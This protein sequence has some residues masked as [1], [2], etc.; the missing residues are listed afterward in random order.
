[1]FSNF[2]DN[3]QFLH[4]AINDKF[5]KYFFNCDTISY[6]NKEIYINAYEKY[7]KDVIEFFSDKKD[8]LLVINIFENNSQTNWKLVCDFLNTEI[9][10]PKENI[11]KNYN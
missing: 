6:E 3:Y 11:N 9:N 7:N 4:D 8:S 10:F 1:M 2:D 5:I